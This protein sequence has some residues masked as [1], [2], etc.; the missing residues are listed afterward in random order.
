MQV[1]LDTLSVLL[2]TFVSDTCKINLMTGRT[3]F[4]A[5]SHLPLKAISLIRAWSVHVEFEVDE[6]ALGQVY[7]RV[8][9]FPC[10]YH[11]TITLHAHTSSGT[12]SDQSSETQSHPIDMT[13]NNINNN[14]V[15]DIS[16]FLF[17]T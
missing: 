1:K 17:M 8:L 7:L 12:N 2:E 13:N 9:L 16:S 5:V 14:L 11:S 15:T 6:V 4:Q 3:I 10:Q